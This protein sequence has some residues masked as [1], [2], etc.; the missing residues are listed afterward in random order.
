MT[1]RHPDFTDVFYANAR[2]RDAARKALDLSEAG[3]KKAA[4]AM[5]KQA[6]HWEKEALRLER[7]I[8]AGGSASRARARKK[9]PRKKAR[10]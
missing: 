6:M 7:A 8:K 3:D 1:A 9:L 5:Y 2:M 4:W 10:D